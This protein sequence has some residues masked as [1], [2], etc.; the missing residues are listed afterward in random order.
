MLAVVDLETSDDAAATGTVV[1]DAVRSIA[2]I[3]EVPIVVAAE[4][5]QMVAESL[6]ER[7]LAE[8]A[9]LA[10]VKHVRSFA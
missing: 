1:D 8:A 2:D 9:S 7:L 5:K 10:T 4:M 6:A 3:A